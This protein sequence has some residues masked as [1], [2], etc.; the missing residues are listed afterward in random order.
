MGKR[1]KK[2][3]KTAGAES[4][5]CRNKRATVDYAIEDRF[6]AGLALMGSEVQSLRSGKA[7][8]SEAYARV[9]DHGEIWLEGAHIAEYPWANRLNH[10]PTRRRKLLL[11]R[12]EISRISVRVIERGYTLVPMALYFKGGYAKLEVGLGK[13]KRR[14]DKRASIKERDVARE[15]DRYR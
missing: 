3:S 5:I 6:E 4:I 14:H 2:Q 8:I 11:N 9:D 12:Q 10:E 7:S 15:N 1:N 13:G